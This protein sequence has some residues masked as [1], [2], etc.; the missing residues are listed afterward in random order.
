MATTGGQ[1]ALLMQLLGLGVSEVNAAHALFAGAR[2][3][4]EAFEIISGDNRHANIK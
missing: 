1:E 4:D 3:V 2:S